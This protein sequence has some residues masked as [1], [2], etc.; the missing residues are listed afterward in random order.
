MSCLN[1]KQSI[2]IVRSPYR[3]ERKCAIQGHGQLP[4]NQW[5]T[6]VIDVVQAWFDGNKMPQKRRWWHLWG[7]ADS[8]CGDNYLHFEKA[9]I[10]GNGS[11][12]CTFERNDIWVE[13]HSE[14]CSTLRCICAIDK[15]LNSSANECWKIHICQWARAQ[16]YQHKME[17]T[18]PDRGQ[19]ASILVTGKGGG[20]TTED[21]V[22]IQ[23]PLL[24]TSTSHHDSAI[25]FNIPYREMN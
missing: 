11:F 21:C 15:Q 4:T 22:V 18:K 1:V 6:A 12:W 3:T 16:S 17:G 13:L 24:M 19:H 25:L 7:C 5:E 2:C 9:R 8:K 20:P 23:S 14:Q 10:F